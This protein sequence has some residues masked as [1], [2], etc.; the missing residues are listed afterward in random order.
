ML[1]CVAVNTMHIHPK[2]VARSRS[3][4]PKARNRTSQHRYNGLFVAATIASMGMSFVLGTHEANAEPQPASAS[5]H[6]TP[7]PKPK[8]R[9]HAA[10]AKPR[11]KPKNANGRSEPVSVA[12]EPE[13]PVFLSEEWIKKDRETENRLKRI[14]NIC[15]GC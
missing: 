6:V 10:D 9:P 11:V 7:N 14:M 3:F 13:P 12:P 2:S 8:E 5:Q 4:T 1:D 15:K